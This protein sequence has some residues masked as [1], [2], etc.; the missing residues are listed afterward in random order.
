MAE[1]TRRLITPLPDIH[2]CI[3]DIYP[4]TPDM[5]IASAQRKKLGALYH[6]LFVLV[7]V[8]TRL[9]DS[10]VTDVVTHVLFL[11]VEFIT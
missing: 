6:H 3:L 7:L 2:S 10:L 5:K 8:R 4:H 11:K 1:F 9:I